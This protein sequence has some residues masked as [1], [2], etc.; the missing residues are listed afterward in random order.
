M[1]L[2]GLL[3]I[4]IPFLSF[5]IMCSHRLEGIENRSL[6]F[7]LSASPLKSPGYLSIGTNKPMD[8]S[9]PGWQA[10]GIMIMIAICGDA[11][12]YCPRYLATKNGS[13]N[14]LEEVKELWVRLGL[15][16]PA[17][18]A[19]DMACCGCRPE[20]KCA[21]S[22]IRNCAH[23]KGIENCGLCQ[24]YPCELIN[25][26]FERSEELSSLAAR[27]CTSEEMGTLHKAF[28]SKRRN[29]DQIHFEKHEDKRKWKNCQQNIPPDHSRSR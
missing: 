9:S 5:S 23:E 27:I 17:F 24:V 26:V 6:L 12:L 11:C 25:A 10:N 22:G 7:H 20:N 19:R 2:R 3:I 28:F 1:A 29:L 4:W 16:E 14:E 21:Y 8:V 15:R 13:D 18:P